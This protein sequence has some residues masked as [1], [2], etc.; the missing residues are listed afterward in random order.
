[1]KLII[2]KD[3][4]ARSK[5]PFY[6][7][8]TKFNEWFLNLDINNE[9]NYFLQLGDFFDEYRPDSKTVSMALNFVKKMKFKNKI[10]LA[11]NLDHSYDV[12]RKTAIE[13]ILLT[14]DNVD[15]DF[16]P[17]IRDIE[18]FKFLTLPWFY[19]N[20]DEKGVMR[21]YYR[22]LSYDEKFDVV[23]YHIEDETI[24]FGKKK[25]IDISQIQAD[26]RLGGHIHKKQLNYDLGM[27]V[28][29]RGDEIG[30]LNELMIIDI[31]T[32]VREIIKVPKFIEYYNITYPEIPNIVS[33]YSILNIKCENKDVAIKFYNETMN[34]IHINKISATNMKNTYQDYYN[35]VF[36]KSKY[37]AELAEEYFKEK[38]IKKNIKG[39]VLENLKM[40]EK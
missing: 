27:P 34:N 4:H 16:S 22:D 12:I 33:E 28:L 1:M 23:F 37:L 5:Y 24:K 6:E 15:V 18:G 21:E 2:M 8:Q 11:G 39:I 35:N 9:N 10:F 19:D 31:K 7:A 36:L 30:Q 17:K 32:K 20:S 13:E 14:I 25:G 40:E 38:N 29:S 26:Y 3:Y